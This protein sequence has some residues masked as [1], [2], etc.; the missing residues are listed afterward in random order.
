MKKRKLV[1]LLLATALAAGALFGCSS[2]GNTNNASKM[3]QSS[4]AVQSSA[5]SNKD[6]S[7]VLRVKQKWLRALLHRGNG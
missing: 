7:A 2:G 5:K 1:S 6:N 3:G 4:Q